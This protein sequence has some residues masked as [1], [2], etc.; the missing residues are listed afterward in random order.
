MATALPDLMAAV[1]NAVHRHR[2][3]TD[4]AAPVLAYWVAPPDHAHHRRLL[5]D[6]GVPCYSATLT[7]ARVA[8]ALARG[9][10]GESS[11]P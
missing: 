7:V 10:V 5:E 2:T 9:A 4:S 8:A 1:T 6:E 3:Q 11:D